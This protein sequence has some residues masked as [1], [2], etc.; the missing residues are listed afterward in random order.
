MKAVIAPSTRRMRSTRTQGAPTATRGRRASAASAV[1]DV[2][3]DEVVRDGHAGRGEVVEEAERRAHDPLVER[4]EAGDERALAAEAVEPPLRD[5]RAD[6]L[7]HDGARD[8]VARAELGL[9]RQGVAGRERARLE[10]AGDDLLELRP[11][12]QPGGGVDLAGPG[13]PPRSGLRERADRRRASA[14]SSGAQRGGAEVAV[15]LRRRCARRRRRSRGPV[16]RED[17]GERERRDARS[18]SDRASG[19]RRRRSGRRRRCSHV[20]RRARRGGRRAANIGAA[21]VRAGQEAVRERR[22]GEHGRRRVRRRARRGPTASAWFSRVAGDHDDVG[23]ADLDRGASLRPRVDRGA[24]QTRRAGLSGLAER[25]HGLVAL[26]D[27]EARVVQQVD[28][29]GLAGEAR[30]RALE[31][32]GAR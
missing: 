7:P 21:P 16:P 26:E 4:C 20:A 3:P 18:R 13:S 17:E 1:H 23:T 12:R 29:D 9:G 31:R 11:Q 19:A 30:E 28:V 2:E 25:R 14:R 15:K 8:A 22:A 10:V 5:E 24:D 32:V 27:V 6:R